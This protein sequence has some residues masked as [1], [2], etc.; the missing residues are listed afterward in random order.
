MLLYCNILKLFSDLYLL[1]QI[2]LEQNLNLYKNISVIT[3]KRHQQ[4]TI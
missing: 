3:Q 1:H 2:I 4:N